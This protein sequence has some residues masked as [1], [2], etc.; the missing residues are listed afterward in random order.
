MKNILAFLALV[1]M[2][3]MVLSC[4]KKEDPVPS[5][6]QNNTVT[7][8][9]KSF[10]PTEIR[11]YYSFTNLSESHVYSDVYVSTDSVNFSKKG[12]LHSRRTA[13]VCAESNLHGNGGFPISI[14]KAGKYY[15]K[16]ITSWRSG[17]SV[18]YN[19]TVTHLAAITVND[20]GTMSIINY[21][22][23]TDHHLVLSACGMNYKL[24][25][26]YPGS[27]YTD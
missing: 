25:A 12:G 5:T 27:Q 17:P 11:G 23:M 18:P 26:H 19:N 6:P 24:T 15:V 16:V 20:D 8:P 10:T 14:D 22:Q 13:G 4:G 3:I 9:P 2:S 21:Q 1:A 7:T